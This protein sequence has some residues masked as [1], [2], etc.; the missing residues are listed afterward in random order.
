MDLVLPFY[1]QQKL[2]RKILGVISRSIHG[3]L[4]ISGMD[5]L[6]PDVFPE[7]CLGE[8]KAIEMRI[9]EVAPAQDAY[10]CSGRTLIALIATAI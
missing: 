9:C 4:T 8:V 6:V 2:E 7:I 3:M 10:N 5:V 1:E